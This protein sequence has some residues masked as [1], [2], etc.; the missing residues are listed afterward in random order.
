MAVDLVWD[1]KLKGPKTPDHSPPTYTKNGGFQIKHDELGRIGK[2]TLNDDGSWRLF[3]EKTFADA[4]ALA[5]FCR[6]FAARLQEKGLDKPK[7]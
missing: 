7:K 3:I 1:Q 5:D 4:I 2:L 6:D